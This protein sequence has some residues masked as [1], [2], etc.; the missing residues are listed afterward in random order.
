MSP[1][2]DGKAT[3]RS[4]PPSIVALG[5]VLLGACT[6]GTQT[7]PDGGVSSVDGAPPT[8]NEDARVPPGVDGGEERCAVACGPAGACCALD[9][10]C[11]LDRCLPRCAGPR[12]GGDAEVCCGAD[13]LCVGGACVEPGAECT[14]EEE[15]GVDETCEPLV[16]R[17][18]PVPEDAICRFVPP[19][20]VFEPV[21]EWS[22]TEEQA[23]SI[24]A[25]VHV[26][27]DD[28][29]GTVGS[30]ADAPDVVVPTWIS[31]ITD[32]HL[33]A[34]S[35]RDGSVLWQTGDE[36]V[37]C[38]QNQPAAG[39]LDGDGTVEILVLA[40]SEGADDCRDDPRLLAFSH[41]GSLE[42]QSSG[43]IGGLT[44][45]SN[46]D[47]P[48]IANL[49]G[50]GRP[51]IVV[52]GSVLDADG[53]VLWHRETLAG[54]SGANLPSVVDVDG[55]GD[56]EILDSHVAYH[57]DGTLLWGPLERWASG[58]T[59]VGWLVDTGAGPVPQ[60]AVV[61]GAELAVLDAAT[62]DVVFGPLAYA[63]PGPLAGPPTLADFDG[64]GRPEIG[65]ATANRYVVFDLQRPPPHEA[66]SVPS[67]DRTTGSVGSTVFDFDA[68]GTAEVA[69][70]DECHLRILSGSG[71]LLWFASNTSGTAWEH[72]VVADVDAD[73]NAEMV[74]VSNLRN[75]D[76]T[77]CDARSMA[78][79]G[80]TR[81]V[82][83]YGDRLDNWVSSRRIWNQH[84]YHIDNVRE[85]GSIPTSPPRTWETH[86]TWRLNAVGEG[87]AT[88]APDLAVTALDGVT[89]ACPAVGTLRARVANRGSRGVPAGVAVAFY[90]GS[91]ASPGRLL[92]VA[93]TRDP[94]LSGA[95]TWV[96]REVR[97][98]PA[99]ER[100]VQFF[101]VVDDDGAGAGSHSECDERNNRSAAVSLD[102]TGPI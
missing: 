50:R 41:E 67:E 62:G 2:H 48:A 54:G 12:C 38:R 24:P 13:E 100:V 46:A 17:C 52:S 59:A 27:D 58:S 1:A 23:E 97:D 3:G 87:T 91:P 21:V 18:L 34:L 47:G 72:P 37:L 68:D 84:A 75:D 83:V 55:D 9:E 69:Y 7:P 6:A 64:D 79:D 57:H 44:E 19:T 22:W 63:E 98:L 95:S 45:N 76:L 73:G 86:N 65:V 5:M 61:D 36:H 89:D 30:P 74:V 71:G 70:A 32:P 77:E 26:N 66:W 88:L 11:V 4:G 49:D 14:E 60:V 39:D 25:I 56:L 85:D 16:G 35:G 82:R 90:A 96:E 29:D 80:Y 8:A 101:A 42:W 78:F 94:L 15:C 10:E 102:C 20:G 40:R 81:G 93:H 99:S 43:R 53:R 33:T 92:G 51:E 31:Y 28:G